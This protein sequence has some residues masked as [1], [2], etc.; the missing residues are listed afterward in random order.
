MFTREELLRSVWR[1]DTFG[2]YQNARHA[3]RSGF[4]GSCARARDDRLVVNVW[5]VGYRL[6][7]AVSTS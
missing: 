4:A 2:A 5:G 7:D 1:L 6:M 3:T